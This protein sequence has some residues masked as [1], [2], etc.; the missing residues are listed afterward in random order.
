MQG[1]HPGVQRTF[2]APAGG[3]VTGTPVLISGTVVIPRETVAAGALFTGFV[4]PGVVPGLPKAAVGI[5][6]GELVRFD[7]LAGNFTNVVAATNYIVGS[8]A[9]VGGVLAGDATVDI[10]FDGAAHIPNT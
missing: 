10:A 7:S 1:F 6:E 8:C 2:T 5:D 3:V 4:G 9:S